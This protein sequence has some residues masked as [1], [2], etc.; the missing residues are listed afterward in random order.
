MGDI[1]SLTLLLLPSAALLFMVGLVGE[2]ATVHA[3]YEAHRRRYGVQPPL[4]VESWLGFGDQV[5]EMRA[6]VNGEDF[7]EEHRRG[8]RM[9]TDAVVEFVSVEA[10]PRFRAARAGRAP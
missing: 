6:V 1:A 7:A 4:D 10:E 8:A 3:A 5:E 2:A 9:T